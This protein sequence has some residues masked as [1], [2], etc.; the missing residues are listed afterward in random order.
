VGTTSKIV[1]LVPS[2]V[3]AF[4]RGLLSFSPVCAL[5]PFSIIE[6]LKKLLTTVGLE[7]AFI[8]KECAV[9]VLVLASAF[10]TL[11]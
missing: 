6:P 9:S 5:V 3:Y 4:I 2:G 7:R 10:L 8:M 11:L 1:A